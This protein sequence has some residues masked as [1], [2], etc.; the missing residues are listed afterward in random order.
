MTRRGLSE[1]LTLLEAAY[2]LK[3]TPQQAQ[4]WQLL[5]APITDEDGKV[6]AVQLCRDS[7][8]PPKPADIFRLVEEAK[9]ARRI[10]RFVPRLPEPADPKVAEKWR[11]FMREAVQ[12]IGKTIQ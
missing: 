11:V 1:V 7:P 8:Y 6:A 9:E 10:P 5:L 2:R 12:K 4:A 3:F